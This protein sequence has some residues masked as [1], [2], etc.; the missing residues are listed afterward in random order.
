MLA[1][2][3]FGRYYLLRVRYESRF[4]SAGV[5]QKAI[6]LYRYA[7]QVSSYGAELPDSIRIPA[8][9]AA[10]SQHE[11]TQEEFHSSYQAFE[12]MLQETYATLNRWERFRFRFLSGLL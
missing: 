2:L 7:L 12:N 11:L 6:L 5:N 1:A 3:L 8:E 4:N 10:F 9:K